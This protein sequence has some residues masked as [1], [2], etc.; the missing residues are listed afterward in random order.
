MA[1]EQNWRAYVAIEERS[2]VREKIRQAYRRNC[3]TYEQLL[4]TVCGI[5]EE[6]I[7][8][9]SVTRMDY[10]K[11]SID[12]DNR[13]LIKNKQLRGLVG[14]GLQSRTEGDYNYSSS[15]DSEDRGDSRKRKADSDSPAD[16]ALFRSTS[17]Q[18]EGSPEVSK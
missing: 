15:P 13:I 5:D 2:A 9:G 6:I 11:S 8:A 14:I 17:R 3:A 1:P 16:P 7:Y 18:G 12:W 10:F 4:E